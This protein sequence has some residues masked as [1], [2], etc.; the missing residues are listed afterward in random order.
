MVAA[1]AM[2]ALICA[3]CVSR[4]DPS[5]VMGTVSSKCP[6]CCGSAIG[7]PMGVC[8][9]VVLVVLFVVFVLVFVPLPEVFDAFDEFVTLLV[10]VRF[11]V[12]LTTGVMFTER[13]GREIFADRF[14]L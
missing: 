9:T 4:M 12:L 13:F 14:V 11:M 5:L 10:F 3:V 6:G 2:Y 1:S 8:S 7:V